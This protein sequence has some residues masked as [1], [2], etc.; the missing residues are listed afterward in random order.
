MAALDD[1]FAADAKLQA[2]AEDSDRLENARRRFETTPPVYKSRPSAEVTQLHTPGPLTE[3]ERRVHHE[4]SD[5]STFRI[6][7]TDQG[8]VINLSCKSRSSP[9]S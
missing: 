6:T 4:R 8:R 2:L 3:E 1:L 5:F 7:G 9:T